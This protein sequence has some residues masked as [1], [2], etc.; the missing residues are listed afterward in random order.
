L[1]EFLAPLNPFGFFDDEQMIG[2]QA[3]VRLAQSGWPEDFS[4]SLRGGAEPEVK[5]KV[6]MGVVT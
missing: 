1:F 6:V 5:T 3:A 2:V 4:V